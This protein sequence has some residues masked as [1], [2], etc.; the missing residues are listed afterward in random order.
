MGKWV[1]LVL[2]PDA[3]QALLG[4][5]REAFGLTA[6]QA[7]ALGGPASVL[8]SIVMAI[9]SSLYLLTQDQSLCSQEVCSNEE[10]AVYQFV[11][12]GLTNQSVLQG[13]SLN[14]SSIAALNAT[15][16]F[17]PEISVLAEL[18][19]LPPVSINDGM[20][21]TYGIG[22]M[23]SFENADFMVRHF[24]IPELLDSHF[25]TSS[26]AAYTSF[27]KMLF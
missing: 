15:L 4:Q 23:F 21:L 16:P 5:L 17:P 11:Q 13:V 24:G 14:I 25:I 2:N 8:N 7:Q 10:L 12:S 19:G 6:E 9:N 27:F 22:T 18:S 3:N 20:Q 26:A 1:G